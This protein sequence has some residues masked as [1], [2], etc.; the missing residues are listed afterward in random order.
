VTSAPSS[1]FH[2]ATAGATAPACSRSRSPQG[3]RYAIGALL[4]VH[5]RRSVSV[6]SKRC[7][8]MLG[9][10]K[11]CLLPGCRYKG[12][13]ASGNLF[14]PVPGCRRDPAHNLRGCGYSPKNSQAR[15]GTAPKHPTHQTCSSLGVALVATKATPGTRSPGAPGGLVLIR[16]WPSRRPRRTTSTQHNEA[17]GKPRQCLIDP[18]SAYITAGPSLPQAMPSIYRQ[19][20]LKAN[21]IPTPP[22]PQVFSTQA[23]RVDSVL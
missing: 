18:S 5:A 1:M 6:R 9:G 19:A 15:S 14:L 17:M 7:K 10:T 20:R 23:L 16:S 4:Y 22:A 3:D 21:G 13:A 2:A 11:T 12:N 8:H